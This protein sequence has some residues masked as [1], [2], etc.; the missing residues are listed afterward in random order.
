MN[1]LQAT[2]E[3]AILSKHTATLKQ[4]KD[5]Q[6][7]FKE[8]ANKAKGQWSIFWLHTCPFTFSIMLSVSNYFQ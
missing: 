8:L 4:I 2:D 7:S 5:Y 3:L 1:I 6:D